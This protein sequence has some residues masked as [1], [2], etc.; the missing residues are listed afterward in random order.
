MYRAFLSHAH[1][2]SKELEPEDSTARLRV[3]TAILEAF[4]RGDFEIEP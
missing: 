2:F 1:K 4:G 3:F